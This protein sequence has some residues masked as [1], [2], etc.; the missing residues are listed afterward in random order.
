M[1]ELESAGAAA[2][3]NAFAEIERFT[4]QYQL[5]LASLRADLGQKKLIMDERQSK[6]RALEEELN[7]EM[8]R[9]EAQLNEQQTL[10][11]RGQ[12]RASGRRSRRYLLFA[13][14]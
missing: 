11:D 1:H 5:E 12:L 7:G 14:R 4:E 8:R 13:K 9:L 6:I 10:L 3:T 2:E